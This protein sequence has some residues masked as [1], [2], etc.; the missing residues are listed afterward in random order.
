MSWLDAKYDLMSWP[1]A[2]V[3]AEL[4]MVVI[5]SHLVGLDLS[6]MCVSEVELEASNH[7]ITSSLMRQSSVYGKDLGTHRFV[8]GMGTVDGLFKATLKDTDA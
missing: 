5:Y 4:R 3:E 1:W 6:F 8:P 7:S 2:S